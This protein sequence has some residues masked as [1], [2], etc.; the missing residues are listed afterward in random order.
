MVTLTG[1][2]GF[3]VGV[4]TGLS[5]L[6]AAFDKPAVQIYCNI[7]RWRTCADWSPHII[8]LGGENEVPSLDEVK[9]AVRKLLACRKRKLP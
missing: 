8:S 7:P 4:D 9:Q 6:A 5:H 1:K 2:A 3:I